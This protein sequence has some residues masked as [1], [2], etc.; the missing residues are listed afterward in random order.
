M[1]LARRLARELDRAVETFAREASSVL[2]EKLSAVGDAGSRRVEK[3]M[4]QI[5]AGLERQRDDL[6]ASL[7]QRLDDYEAEF[8]RRLQSFVADANAERAVLEARLQEL[9][10]R[11]D[12][13]VQNARERLSILETRSR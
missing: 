11:V 1:P 12:E 9:D 8:R 5:A 4:S 6:A 13:A 2:G 3:R 10:R 7:E